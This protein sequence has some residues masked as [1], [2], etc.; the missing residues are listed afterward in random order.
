[1]KLKKALLCTVL[2]ASFLAALFFGAEQLSVPDIFCTHD[3]FSKTVF[4]NLRLPRALLCLLSGSL[5][6]GA[7]AA[8]Q[9]Y[10]RN[11]LAEPGIL[12][13]SSG[14]TLG[15]VAAA[16]CMAKGTESLS[17]PIG[18]FCGALCSGLIIIMLAGKK[19]HSTVLILLCGTALG[20]LYSAF[21]SILLSIHSKRL[22]SMYIWMLGS[23]SGRSW[24]ELL[25]ILPPFLGTVLLLF[26]CSTQLDLLS[27]GENAAR[28]LG[29]SVEMLRLLV[30]TAGSLATSAAVS[31]GGT[32]GFIGLI[33]PHIIRRCFGAKAAAVI[34]FS[35]A[36]GGALMLLS[37]TIARTV[38][39]PAELP[40]GTVTA[41]L[42]APFFISLLFLKRKVQNG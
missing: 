1:M 22:Y 10:F 13:I 35:M 37:D 31:A 23:F 42:G 14:S 18:A 7:G 19:S 9:L 2:A 30:L 27:G 17:V 39:A 25:F 11:P 16:S 38:I 6:A 34:F 3:S 28:A 32:I 21:S 41:L 12:G 8:F 36:G 5:L 15:A 40:V 26:L 4:F 24:K 20:T 33:A 29:A